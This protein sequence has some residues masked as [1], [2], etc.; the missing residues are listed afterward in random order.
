MSDEK[1][2]D[3]RLQ[4]KEQAFQKLHLAS[5]DVVAHISAIQN[6]VQQANRDVSPE[7]EDFIALVEKFSA[8]VTEC[9]E[10]EANIAALIEH[11]QHLLDNEGV[12]NA[13]KGQA[14][15]IALN[16]LHHWLILKDIPEDLLA[17]DEVSGTIKERF[18][19]HL[20]MWHKTFYGDATAH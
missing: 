17:V 14:C 13:A 2:V 15:A 6:L 3:P 8:I 16:T 12:A 5:F 20:S 4:A 1:F 9:N 18:M 11:T 19:M 7:N 10:P